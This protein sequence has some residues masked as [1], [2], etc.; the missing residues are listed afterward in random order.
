MF[1]RVRP[2]RCF[3]RAAIAASARAF[4]SSPTLPDLRAGDEVLAARFL[5]RQ[6]L[7]LSRSTERSGSDRIGKN[8]RQASSGVTGSS[9]STFGGGDWRFSRWGSD[10]PALSAHLAPKALALDLPTSKRKARRATPAQHISTQLERRSQGGERGLGVN[11]TAMESEPMPEYRRRRAGGVWHWC[12]NCP[13][14]PDSDFLVRGD[15]PERD[16]DLCP[17][18]LGDRDDIEGEAKSAEAR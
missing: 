9:S 18:C 6:F 11:P 10:L 14:Y 13:T 17:T 1:C 16:Q 8:Q 12:R 3:G 7:A 5:D 2:W 15:R 4:A